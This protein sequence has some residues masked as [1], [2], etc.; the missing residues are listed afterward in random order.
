[1][2]VQNKGHTLSAMATPNS[3]TKAPVEG[4][5]ALGSRRDVRLNPGQPRDPAYVFQKIF[6]APVAQR[7]EVDLSDKT[8]REVESHFDGFV[9]LA[10]RNLWTKAALL[11]VDA[12]EHTIVFANGCVVRFWKSR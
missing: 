8:E 10:Q 5:K 9:E 4:S 7:V 2:Q 6:Q 1:M 12:S 11:K 3:S